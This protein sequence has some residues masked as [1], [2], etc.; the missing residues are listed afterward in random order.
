MV[1]AMGNVNLPAALHLNVMKK[2][3]VQVSW[4]REEYV[5]IVYLLLLVVLSAV[6]LMLMGNVMENV[7]IAMFQKVLLPGQ[8]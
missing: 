6:L 1:L 2:V 8:M 4:Y 7:N 3:L 5:I